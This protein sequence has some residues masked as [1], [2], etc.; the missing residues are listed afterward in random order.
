MEDG[1]GTDFGVGRL[2][3][4]GSRWPYRR[5]WFPFLGFGWGLLLLVPMLLFIGLSFV[6]LLLRLIF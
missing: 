1:E 3:L 4:W 6:G 2:V 5:P